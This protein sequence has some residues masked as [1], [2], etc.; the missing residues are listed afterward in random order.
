M[1][2]EVRAVARSLDHRF[3]KA[4][5]AS[6]EL[7]AGFGIEGDAH[8]GITV[9]HRSR[10]RADPTQPNLR[11]VHL[12]HDELFAEMTALGFAVLP[13]ELGENITTRGIDLL[14]LPRGRR[15]QFGKQAVVR[16]TGLR[17]PCAQIDRFEAGLMRAV[18]DQD[19]DGRLVRKAGVMAVVEVDGTVRPGDSIV[20]ELPNGPHDRLKPV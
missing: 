4:L 13:G 3:S 19:V 15:L 2:G 1:V 20:V 14:H 5:V 6:V 18:L 7:I 16:L 10:V 12:I 17:N 8:A 9:Q 11:Q